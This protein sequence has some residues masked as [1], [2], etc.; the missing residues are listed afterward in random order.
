MDPLLIGGAILLLILAT[1]KGN[2][3]LRWPVDIGIRITSLYGEKR[4]DRVHSGVD[5]AAPVGTPVFAM[6]DGVISKYWTDNIYGGGLSMQL[7]HEGNITVGFAHLSVNNLLP[8]GTRVKKG[9][10][11]AYTGNTGSSTGPHLHITI[12][13]MNERIDPLTVLPKF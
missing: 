1:N 7:V 10:L 11:V 3:S 2:T 6:A 5:I 4:G 13:K 12:Y 8:S 9:Q